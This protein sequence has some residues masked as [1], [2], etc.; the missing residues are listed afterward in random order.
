MVSMKPLPRCEGRTELGQ[1]EYPH[2]LE[3][4]RWAAKELLCFKE[5][6]GANSTLACSFVQTAPGSRQQ[7]TSLDCHPSPGT[8]ACRPAKASEGL[9]QQQMGAGNP[10]ESLTSC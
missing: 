4:G 3:L 5:R 1:N 7:A 8:Y 10:E 9:G 6:L 2:H